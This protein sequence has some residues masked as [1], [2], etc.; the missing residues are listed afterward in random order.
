M[1]LSFSDWYSAI[2]SSS[3]CFLAFSTA[4]VYFS[5]FTPCILFPSCR[6]NLERK[7][8]E[9]KKEKKKELVDANKKKKKKEKKRKNL[10]N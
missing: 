3:A 9:K 10:A 7:R 2:F 4:S 6:E 1:I 5:L 8:K